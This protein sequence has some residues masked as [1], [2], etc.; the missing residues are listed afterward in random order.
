MAYIQ[1]F[2]CSTCE[3][4]AVVEAKDNGIRVTPCNCQFEEENN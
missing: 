2:F 3:G 4:Y 1:G